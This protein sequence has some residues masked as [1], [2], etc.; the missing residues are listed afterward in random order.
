MAGTVEQEL[1]TALADIHYTHKGLVILLA[2][3]LLDLG[4]MDYSAKRV[5]KTLLDDPEMAREIK[6]AFREKIH[7]L[8]GRPVE[9]GEPVGPWESIEILEKTGRVGSSSYPPMELVPRNYF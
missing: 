9:P 1:V 5:Y 7:G 3:V 8:L 6:T 4:R 2:N